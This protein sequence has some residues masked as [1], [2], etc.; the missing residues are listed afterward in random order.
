MKKPTSYLILGHGGIL[1]DAMATRLD[2]LVDGHRIFFFD[3]NN[4]DITDSAQ[5]SPLIEY[6]RPSVV[7]NCA[8]LNDRDICEDA[9]VGAFNVNGRG[10]QFLAEQCKKYGAKLVHFSSAD[11]YSGGHDSMDEESETKPINVLGQ[12]KLSGEAAIKETDCEYLIIRPG[13]VFHSN[14]DNVLIR[15]LEKAD[16]G[17]EIV[18]LRD[19]FVSPTYVLDLM[20]ATVNLILCDAKGVFNVCNKGGPVILD[21]FVRA[22]LTTAGAK[23]RV[24]TVDASSQKFWKAESPMF[25][26]LA[27]KKYEDK[28]ASFIRSWEEALKHC[29]F[30]MNRYSPS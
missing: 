7:I 2:G 18:V 17:E 9:K 26:H 8:A 4:V 24:S 28:T 25:S 15:W 12:S 21:D 23:P 20:D 10:P 19:R 1:G 29:L 22:V 13:M 14:G 16:Q 3:H 11:V 5:I 27:I 6:I 30:S